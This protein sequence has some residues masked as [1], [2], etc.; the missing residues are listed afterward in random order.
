LFRHFGSKEKLIQEALCRAG[1]TLA[2]PPLPDN[3]TDPER[4]LTEWCRYHMLRLNAAAPLIRTCMGEFEERPDVSAFGCEGPTKVAKELRQYLERLQE[5][6]W[7]NAG[8]DTN[9]AAAML[10]GAIFSDAVSRDLMPERYPYEMDEAAG[11]YVGIFLRGIAHGEPSE[12]GEDK[13]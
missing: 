9:A 8:Q 10:M 3:P 12:I 4:E 5:A 2:V 13:E 11:H 7:M 6:G 1:Q